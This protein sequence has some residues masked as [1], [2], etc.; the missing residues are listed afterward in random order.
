MDNFLTIAITRPDFFNHEAE[1]INDILINRKA[2]FVHLRKPYSSIYEI[3]TLLSKIDHVNI[4]RIKIHDH[5][6]LLNIYPLGGAH[7]NSRNPRCDL[8]AKSLSKSIHSINEISQ[9]EKFDYLFL[10]PIFDSISKTGYKAA[11]SLDSL[12]MK[13]R[14]KN[15][16]A[17]GGVTPQKFQLLKDMGFKGAAMLGYFFPA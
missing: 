9:S 1:M 12:S 17:L 13:V 16:V 15:I 6:E 2:D 7:L 3:E 14:N 11:F 10:S 8:P 4:P 5:F